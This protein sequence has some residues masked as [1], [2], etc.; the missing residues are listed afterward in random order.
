MLTDHAP[1]VSKEE[2]ETTDDMERL[3]R[4]GSEMTIHRGTTEDG[5]PDAERLLE[6]RTSHQAGLT[7]VD[8]SGDLEDEDRDAFRQ[9]LTQSMENAGE[10]GDLALDISAV[11]YIS[12]G[13]LAVLIN[14]LK[15]LKQQGRALHLIRPSPFVRRKL[16]RMAVNKF[17][18]KDED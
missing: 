9:A 12:E 16:E 6:F 5:D 2:S 7:V 4:E 1:G 14:A 10:T 3:R 15:V 8:V 13:A 18:F 11:S 17:F